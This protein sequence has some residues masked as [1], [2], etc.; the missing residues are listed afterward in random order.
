MLSI[1]RWDNP[2]NGDLLMMK[3][4]GFR[5]V[6]GIPQSS[7]SRHGRPW[8]SPIFRNP[9]NGSSFFMP[10]PADSVHFCYVGD[11]NFLPILIL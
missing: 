3:N 11:I 1:Y 9:G 5:A 8:G 2:R 6:M 4:G 10:R 7:S